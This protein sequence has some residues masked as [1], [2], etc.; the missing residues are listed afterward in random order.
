MTNIIIADDHT[1]FLEGLISLLRNVPEINV[2]GKAS[3]GK[4]LLKLLEENTADVLL[5]DIS[6]PE[7]DGIDATKILARALI[8]AFSPEDLK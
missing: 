7:M 6:M 1:M 3:N 5:L 2:T 4:E 8:M